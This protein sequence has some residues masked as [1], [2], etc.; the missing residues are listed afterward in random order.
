MLYKIAHLLRDHCTWIWDIAEAMNS[1]AFSIRY[2][3]ELKSVPQVLAK[4][5]TEKVLL[6]EALPQD[7]EAM[8]LFFAKQPEEDFEFF[9]PH[10]FD[11]E[12]LRVL[13]KRSSFMMFVAEMPA[14]QASSSG[15]ADSCQKEIV[16][17]FFLRSFV[18]GQSYLGKMV[19]HAHQGQGIGKLMCKAAMDVALTLG[20]RMFES[21]NKENMASMRSTG[22]VLK[23][24]VLEEL[25]HGDLLIEDLPLSE[26]PNIK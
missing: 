17:Y 11:A 21:I 8:A 22:A 4:N 10:G 16:G 12:S 23:Q 6:R 1:F 7:A 15:I 19:D 18:H 14:N 26:I 2:K 25:E 24:V 5:N 13:L 9:R 20:V 3:K